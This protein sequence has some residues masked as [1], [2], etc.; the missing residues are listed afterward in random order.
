MGTP[1]LE[2]EVAA[3]GRKAERETQSSQPVQRTKGVGGWPRTGERGMEP[4]PSMAGFP[5]GFL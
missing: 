5:C 3:P 4:G 2:P 1:G